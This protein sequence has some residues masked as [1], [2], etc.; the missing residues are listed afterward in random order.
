MEI[1]ELK[2]E[3]ESR[4]SRVE[5]ESRKSRVVSGKSGVE[6]GLKSRISCSLKLSNIDEKK[7]VRLLRNVPFS[8][9]NS[10]F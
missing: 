3:S 9:L 10:A 8:T 4:K 2:F 5:I 6:N 1:R 7:F